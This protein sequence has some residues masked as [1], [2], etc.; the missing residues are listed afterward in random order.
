MSQS[1]KCLLVITTKYSLKVWFL[2]TV[3][4]YLLRHNLK[5]ATSFI[6]SIFAYSHL[7]FG[8]D[9]L[10][11]G[12]AFVIHTCGNHVYSRL[13]RVFT[14]RR[15]KY[16]FFI[17][18]TDAVAINLLAYRWLKYVQSN[19]TLEQATKAQRGSK[20]VAVLFL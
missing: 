6:M 18:H 11:G 10:F 7:L 9:K 12:L 4:M 3:L 20:G 15:N 14:Y 13:F 8:K 5:K 19:F 1:E 2:F 17:P 16:I